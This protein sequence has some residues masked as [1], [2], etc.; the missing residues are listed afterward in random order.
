MTVISISN[1][2]KFSEA[3]DRYMFITF[4]KLNFSQTQDF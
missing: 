4:D 3:K 1:L 2:H